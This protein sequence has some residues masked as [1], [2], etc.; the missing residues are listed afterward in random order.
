MTLQTFF[1]EAKAF[2]LVAIVITFVAIVAYALWPS[3]QS[4][5]D[6]AASLPLNED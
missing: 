3:N 1:Y 5:F 4:K 2:S 6:E